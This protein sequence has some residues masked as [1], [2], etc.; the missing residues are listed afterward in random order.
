MS[1]FPFYPLRVEAEG[2]IFE[3][4]GWRWI[5]YLLYFAPKALLMIKTSAHAPEETSAFSSCENSSVIIC[6][7][8]ENVQ[9]GDKGIYGIA[10]NIGLR[11]LRPSSVWDHLQDSSLTLL[12]HTAPPPAEH[13]C[14][15]FSG[16]SL[17]TERG[18]GKFILAP[19]RLDI[20]RFWLNW[21]PS[22]SGRRF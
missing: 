14:V 2:H 15:S 4:N 7:I 13:H 20:E 8:M 22:Y 3:A 19:L 6:S 12:A 11:W 21:P 1:S 10:C 9:K 18:L 5:H 17:H 16:L